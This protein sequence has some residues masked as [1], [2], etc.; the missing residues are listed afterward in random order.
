[1]DVYRDMTFQDM[2]EF[3]PYRGN[4]YTKYEILIDPRDGT[5]ELTPEAEN[6][7]EYTGK[8]LRKP[9]RD[10]ECFNRE[11]YTTS[12]NRN[13]LDGDLE[14]LIPEGGETWW[15]KDEHYADKTS[16]AKN[17]KPPFDTIGVDM[18]LMPLGSTLS[19]DGTTVILPN[20]VKVNIQDQSYILP[21]GHERLPNGEVLLPDG[22]KI[23]EGGRIELTDG[24]IIYPDQFFKNQTENM[25][26]DGT[27]GDYGDWGAGEYNAGNPKQN[28]GTNMTSMVTDRSRVFKGGSW[29][30]RAY[31]LVP[32]T[33]RFLDEKMARADLGF[34]CAMHRVGSPMQSK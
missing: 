24:S 22:S 17:M 20:G 6:Y 18:S 8:I 30:D 28:K 31:W 19:S 1:M 5:I 25:Y 11:N 23:L 2:N 10:E 9:V 4:V 16:T 26:D 29:N 34:R 21:S 33:R 32:G 13:Y 15:N 27:W 12:D 7:F 3:R 14:S